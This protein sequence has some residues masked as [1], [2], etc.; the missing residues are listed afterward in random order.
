MIEFSYLFSFGF[1]VIK[2]AIKLIK[3][4]NIIVKNK[5]ET[6]SNLGSNDNSNDIVSINDINEYK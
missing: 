3:T 1:L 5:T 6:K 4:K 2:V